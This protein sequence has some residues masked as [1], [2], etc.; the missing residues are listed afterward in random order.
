MPLNDKQLEI[1]HTKEPKCVV[2]AAAAAGKTA[3]MVERV[4]YLLDSGVPTGD[5]VVITFTNLAANEMQERLGRP[6]GIFI[7]TTHSYANYLLLS[8]GIDTGKVLESE[9]FDKLFHMVTDNPHCVKKVKYLIVDEAQDCNDLQFEFFEMINPEN[10]MYIG[11]LRQSIYMFAGATPDN[12]R[13]I[14]K[15]K[16]VTVF[17][18]NQNY[19]N[20]I[21][22][23][24]FAKTIIS[25]ILID[26]SIAM[27]RSRGFV[28]TV[29]LSAD[30]LIRQIEIRPEYKSWFVLCRTNAE[31]EWADEILKKAEIPCDIIRRADFDTKQEL[32]EKLAA[33]TVKVM[34]I[35]SSKGL[36][37]DYVFAIGMKYFNE[38]ERCISYVAATRAKHLLVLAKKPYAKRPTYQ[39]KFQTKS[40]E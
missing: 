29:D 27:S 12:L 13:A 16:D 36:E 4:R 9:K 7:G 21:S 5:I 10:F 6:E 22:I 25:P 34:T 19:R 15:Q 40:W 1:V 31:V 23:L 35:H 14:S 30:E 24:D 26:T 37:N 20:D 17:D 11:D 3:T 18:L 2:I 28:R 32:E 33:E 38:E 8:S 39:K